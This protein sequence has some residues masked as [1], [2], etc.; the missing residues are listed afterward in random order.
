MPADEVA[1]GTKTLNISG[2]QLRKKL[3]TGAPIP[4][5]F[6]YPEVQNI[7][8]SA[9]PPRSKQGFV[10]LIAGDQSVGVP[11]I[12]ST[13]TPVAVPESTI[14]SAAE[15]L[16]AATSTAS[17]AVS[18]TLQ[19]TSNTSSNS[20]STIASAAISV[21]NQGGERPTTLISD[22]FNGDAESIGF[23]AANIA[24]NGGAVVVYSPSL[25]SDK[26]REIVRR[27]VEKQNGGFVSVYVKS[28]GT[29]DWNGSVK[30]EVVVDA[31]KQHVSQIVHEVILELEKEGFVGSR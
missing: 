23:V 22:E 3:K 9:Y 26:Q 24:K 19:V 17:P 6:T 27:A 20:I 1:A 7:L 30:A 12:V 4:A 2:T 13:V 25:S 28:S 15:S 18:Q 5:W 16:V 14:A 21:L 11:T 10:V 8:K 31:T 29:A